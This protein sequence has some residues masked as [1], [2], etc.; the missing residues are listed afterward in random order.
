MQTENK[1][2]ILDFIFILCVVSFIFVVAIVYQNY[3][4]VSDIT[5]TSGNDFY[6]Q[7]TYLKS[8]QTIIG[9]KDEYCNPIISSDIGI[10]YFLCK[11]NRR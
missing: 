7:T 8:N 9:M 2:R 6:H 1:I 10:I 11:E 4:N 5:E 3:S